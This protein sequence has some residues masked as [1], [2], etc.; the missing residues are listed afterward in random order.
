LRIL[1]PFIVG[2]LVANPPL[3]RADAID[4]ANW[5]RLHGCRSAA[6]HT[7]LRNSATLQQAAKRLASGIS[8]HDALAAVGYLAAQSSALHLSGAVS[9]AQV[10]RTLT[11][12]YCGTLTNP[13]LRDIGIER[14][15]HEV[16]IVLAAPVSLP[17][18][19]DASSVPRR[20]LD[21][22]NEARAAGRRC[23]GKYFPPVAALTLNVS[24]G[25]AALAHS[26]DMAQHGEFDHLGHDGSTPELRVQR[27]GYGNYRIVG[28]N[29]AAGAMTP[30]EVTQGWLASPP[31]CENIMDGRFTQ[32]GIAFAANLKNA[33]GLYWTQDFA[34][35]RQ[36]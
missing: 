32:I 19:A 14:R 33:A 20:I 31:H 35:P 24:L 28:E 23:G 17:T 4:A 26:R 10:S 22:V 34:A 1:L 25:N 21:L 16:W 11:G 13:Q 18:S 15:G 5:G 30:P 36:H 12:N 7:A 8:L 9:D 29:I 2:L 27:A 3:A 6:T